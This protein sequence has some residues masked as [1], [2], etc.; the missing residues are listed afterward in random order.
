M[1]QVQIKYYI[2]Y[3]LTGIQIAFSIQSNQQLIDFK[4]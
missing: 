2:A 3:L 4:I 1:I